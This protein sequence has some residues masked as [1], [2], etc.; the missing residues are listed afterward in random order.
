MSDFSEHW[1]R[2]LDQI[3]VQVRELQVVRDRIAGVLDD[4]DERINDLERLEQNAMERLA[5][6]VR[7]SAS[8][9]A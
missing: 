9:E 3:R 7:S 2:R 5:E 6:P 8:N 4:I 1:T